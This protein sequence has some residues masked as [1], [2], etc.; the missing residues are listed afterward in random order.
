MSQR[1]E[2]LEELLQF[3]T[4][5]LRFCENI[6]QLSALLNEAVDG[7][8][9]TLR[10]DVAKKAMDAALEEGT[11]LQ[12]IG[13]KGSELMAAYVRKTKQDLERWNELNGRS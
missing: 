4:K 7:A 6:A 5:S 10:D 11:R 2:D 8:S 1:D 3:Q 13:R 12:Q 9:E